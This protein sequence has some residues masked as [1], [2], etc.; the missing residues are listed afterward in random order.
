MSLVLEYVTIVV[1]SWD[2][3]TNM[4]SERVSDRV[5]FTE[6]FQARAIAKTII[7]TIKMEIYANVRFIRYKF[8]QKIMNVIIAR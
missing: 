3:P 6:V 7:E 1:L 5:A 8:V 4:V 2:D